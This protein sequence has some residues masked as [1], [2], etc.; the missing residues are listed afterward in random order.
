MERWRK[1]EGM[2]KW[3]MKDDNV[4]ECMKINRELCISNYILGTISLLHCIQ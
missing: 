1:V 4:N 3:Y 2:S